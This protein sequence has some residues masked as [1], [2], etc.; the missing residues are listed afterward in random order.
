VNA[1]DIRN[2]CSRDW[3]LIE[4]SKVDFW[5]ERKRTMTPAEILAVAGDLFEYAQKMK[6]GW[7]TLQD[8]EDDLRSHIRV[9]GLLRRAQ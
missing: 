7:P 5:T 9:A 2:Y 8:R 1:E 4:R 3:R 6:P